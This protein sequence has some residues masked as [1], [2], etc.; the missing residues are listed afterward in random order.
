MSAAT[1]RGFGAASAV[2][3]GNQLKFKDMLTKIE[4]FAICGVVAV[5]IVSVG[6]LVLGL[7]KLGAFLNDIIKQ[8]KQ[9]NCEHQFS[10]FIDDCPGG[11]IRCTE[12]DKQLK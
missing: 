11:S 10:K 3:K 2:N 5:L 4:S 7:V 1:V 12:C 6:F 8:E 9:E